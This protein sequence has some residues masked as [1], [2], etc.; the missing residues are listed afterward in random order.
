MGGT[1][2]FVIFTLCMASFT[3]IFYI[4]FTRDFLN[5]MFALKDLSFDHLNTS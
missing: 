5:F 1:I 3:I 2:F 4:V